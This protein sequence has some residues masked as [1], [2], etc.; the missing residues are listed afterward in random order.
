MNALMKNPDGSIETLQEHGIN[1]ATNVIKLS[2]TWP[3]NYCPYIY[4]YIYIYI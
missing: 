2:V 1:A 3:I 4:I